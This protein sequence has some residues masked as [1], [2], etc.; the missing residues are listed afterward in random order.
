MKN[1][2]PLRLTAYRA[3]T[4]PAPQIFAN[5]PSGGGSPALIFLFK[6]MT[7]ILFLASGQVGFSQVYIQPCPPPE[8]PNFNIPTPIPC[9]TFTFDIVIGSGA[10]KGT[11]S[12]V[13]A[14]LTGLTVA[15][16]GNFV[17]NEDFSFID[18]TVVID[19]GT[20]IVATTTLATTN[21]TID[22]SLLRGCDKMWQ[23]IRLANNTRIITRNISQIEDAEVAIRS[24]TQSWLDLRSTTFNR[25]R[26]G[27]DL[28]T[29]Q[30]IPVIEFFQSCSFSCTT[31][32]SDP[33]NPNA[34]SETGI[35]SRNVPIVATSPIGIYN[36]KFEQQ[37]YGIRDM[38][39]NNQPLTIVGLNL[40]F[41]N[42]REDGIRV[43]HGNITLTAST[44]TNCVWHGIN[45]EVI[46]QML[47]RGGSFRFNQVLG[48]PANAT[49]R[50]GIYVNQFAMGARME[51]LGGTLFF[52]DQLNAPN[53]TTF[54]IYLNGST[55]GAN[56]LVLIHGAKFD[57]LA[58][59]FT[60]IFINGNFP[61]QSR[62]QI[63]ENSFEMDTNFTNAHGADSQAIYCT[64][65]D[66]S[67]IK[68]YSNN[69]IDGKLDNGVAFYGISLEGSTGENNTVSY[70]TFPT[71]YTYA[72]EWWNDNYLYAI[73]AFNFEN[74]TYCGND[75][76]DCGIQLSLRFMCPGTSVF[77]NTMRGG[78]VQFLLEGLIGNQGASD[79]N[80]NPPVHI[81]SAN[82][83]YREF[84]G[85]TPGFAAK[86]QNTDCTQ[87]L[88]I[89]H[90]TPTILSVNQPSFY[91]DLLHITP[92]AGWFQEDLQAVPLICV[93]E[94]FTDDSPSK[95]LYHTIADGGV[96]TLTTPA[97]KWQLD[98]HLYKKLRHNPALQSEYANYA[99]F[100]SAKASGTVGKFYDVQELISE[101][102]DASSSQTASAQSYQSQYGVAITALAAVD[103]LLSVS[104]D[105]SV[106][107]YN[108]S[109]KT[110]L[111]NNLV[112]L[113]GLSGLLEAGYRAGMA[114]KLNQ[115]NQMNAT[116]VATTVYEIN[117]KTVNDLWLHSKLQQAGNFTE[118]QMA[119][120]RDIAAQCPA[121]GGQAVY[122]ARGLMPTCEQGIYSSDTTDC[123][124]NGLRISNE[125]RTVRVSNDDG[126]IVNPNPAQDIL[127]VN[128]PSEQSAIVSLIALT[129]SIVRAY[130]CAGGENR[131]SL[132]DLP[133]GIYLCRIQTKTGALH[134]EK[135]VVQR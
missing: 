26:V 124:G 98:R 10:G 35:I 51:V 16:S 37:R 15:I 62:V 81:A 7:L 83:W 135:I 66:K 40:K 84:P 41:N 45:A 119:V 59:H 104:T 43:L 65:G 108:L 23:G 101:A 107:T 130:S 63:Y 20:I 123:S 46:H 67:N 57:F 118:S 17:I 49:E 88:L 14:N 106:I 127:W 13:G 103:S 94:Q 54:G 132:S 121:E 111:I 77:D 21:F 120:L 2:L 39:L 71:D 90:T 73:N 53:S 131:L 44:F 112:Q 19:G 22:H 117:E 38:S 32:L 33:F 97:E 28:S 72:G 125:E 64:G 42:I 96:I 75:I 95:D 86:C 55:V 30:G 79:P 58:H 110:A 48:T 9:N 27:L 68:I 24:G 47:I 69:P 6:A 105:G 5:F 129:G 3:E 74:T 36:I 91:P 82:K 89:V 109:Q 113:D 56:T 25:N 76:G 85:L 128:L 115:A 133:N 114:T 102:F 92:Q 1:I 126:I 31:F 134:T 4:R 100:L 78:S 8:I 116:I 50:Y 93:P 61:I 99:S 12:L 122:R 60:G 18:C 80:A 34:L 70:N 52:V 11:S 87:S 29:A